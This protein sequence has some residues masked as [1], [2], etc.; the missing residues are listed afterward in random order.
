MTLPFSTGSRTAGNLEGC[1]SGRMGTLGKRVRCK[2]PWV[3]IPHPPPK[4]TPASGPGFATFTPSGPWQAR[5][6]GMTAPRHRWVV[7][8]GLVAVYFSFG[9]GVAAIAPMLTL[10]R[11]DLGASRGEMGLALGSWTMIYIVTSPIAGR[12][13]D[14]FDLGWSLFLGGCSVVGSLLLRSMAEGVG[15]LWLAVAFFGVFGPLVSA[16]APALMAKWFPDEKERRLGIGLYAAA[17]AVGGTLI[18]AIT[19]PV[20]LEWLETWQ[21]VLVF[22]A[23]VAALLTTVWV[24]IWLR[25]ERPDCESA[26]EK[27][28]AAGS[29]RRLLRSPQIR[30]N[31]VTAFALFFVMHALGTWLPTVLEEHGEMSATAAGGWVATAGV[32]AIVLT[33][34]LPSQATPDRM[35]LMFGGLLAATAVA[36]AIVAFGPVDVMGPAT[37]AG[38]LRSPLVPIGIVT[39]LEADEVTP[40]N[41]GLANGL[42]FS[43]AQVGGVSGPLTLGAVADTSLGYEGALTAVVVIAFLGVGF[44]SIQHRVYRRTEAPLSH[45]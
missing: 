7:F 40:A 43:A 10:V 29:T 44:A 36:V 16:S 5:L 2:P 1:Q 19:N 24:V 27:A 18:V 15:T 38:A 22:E 45:S 13:I 25:I 20:L 4:R 42:W 34:T 37:L 23:G 35:H 14:R 11:E 8:G 39:L 30:L 12:F 41:A 31:F 21:R 33:A 9:I 32:F 28:A 3:Q 26:V 6:T 17:P